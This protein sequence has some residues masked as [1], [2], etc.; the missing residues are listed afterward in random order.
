MVPRRVS[1]PLTGLRCFDSRSAQPK[2]GYTCLKWQ[3]GISLKGDI[4]MWSGPHL[5]IAADS[6]IWEETWDEHPFY[7]WERWLADLGY[8]G[9]MGLLYKYKRDGGRQLNRAE[10]YFNNLQEFVRNRIENVVSQLKRH[11]LFQK[12]AYSGSM[13]HLIPLVKIVGHV[14]AYE[15]HEVGPRFTCYGPWTHN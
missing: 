13:D 15:V 2:Y 8:V 4:I 7:G 1:P 3:L 12:G 9:C 6:T 14:T 5:G 10:V 11:R